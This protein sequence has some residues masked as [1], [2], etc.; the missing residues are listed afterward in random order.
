MMVADPL[1]PGFDEKQEV[2]DILR[3]F[4]VWGLVVDAIDAADHSVVSEGYFVGD[5]DRGVLVLLSH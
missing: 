3:L 4:H 2:G 5:V 1:G